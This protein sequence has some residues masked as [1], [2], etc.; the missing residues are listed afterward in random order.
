MRLA[1]VVIIISGLC[2]ACGGQSASNKPEGTSAAM[3]DA[4]GSGGVNPEGAAGAIDTGGTRAFVPDHGCASDDDCNPGEVCLQF[5]P[6]GPSECAAR[7][8]PV[9]SCNPPND[10]DQCC[11]TGECSSGACFTTVVA[12]GLVCG[13][14]GFDSFNQCLSDGCASDADCSAGQSCLPTGFG[15]LKECMPANC[16]TDADCT[17]DTGGA[18]IAFGDRCCFTAAYPRKYRPKQL[19]CVYASDGCKEDS[20]CPS[21]QYC[22]VESGRAHCSDTCQ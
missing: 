13:L 10:R 21:M 1:R 4:G 16:R 5:T 11:S 18:C 20:D 2:S 9:T 3:P 17:D 19:T 22:V 7:R 6:G 12:A 8:A 15:S 14:G